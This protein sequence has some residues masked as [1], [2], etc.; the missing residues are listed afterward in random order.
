ML[1]IF[2]LG[3]PL[4]LILGLTGFAIFKHYQY[5]KFNTWANKAFNQGLE[6]SGLSVKQIYDIIDSRQSVYAKVKIFQKYSHFKEKNYN[7]STK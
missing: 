7:S 6:F 3:L 2:L 4:I 1:N 5:R